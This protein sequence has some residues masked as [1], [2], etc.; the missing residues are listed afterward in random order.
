MGGVRP[1]DGVA[2]LVVDDN[3]DARDMMSAA[4]THQGANVTACDS[5]AEARGVLG[6]VVPDVIVSD[7]SMPLETGMTMMQ[8][9]RRLPVEHGGTVPALAI[10][11]FRHRFTRARALTAGFDAYLEKP[12]DPWELCRVVAKLAKRIA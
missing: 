5:A 6:R 7:L 12:V 4:L 2:V 11:A 8:S 1:L 10:T 9:I 3:V